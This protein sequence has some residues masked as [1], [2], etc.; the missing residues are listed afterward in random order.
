MK[1]K[2]VGAF[3]CK[4]DAK[5]LTYTLERLSE[6]C[7]LIVA[8]DDG[9]TD[10]S[11]DII[12]SFP[13]V[14]KFLRHPPGKKFDHELNNRKLVNEIRKIDPEW[15]MLIDPDDLVDKRFL[16]KKEELLNAKDVG[17]YTFQEISLWGGKTHYRVDQPEAYAR[18]V[19]YTPLLIRWNPSIKLTIAHHIS[20]R[21]RLV[22]FLSGSLPIRLMKLYLPLRSKNFQS[23]FLRE[24]FFPSDYMSHT[25]FRFTGI[26]GKEVNLDLKK[27][28]YHF[29]DWEYACKKHVNYALQAAIR[30]GRKV[31]EVPDIADWATAR[32]NSEGLILERVSYEWGVL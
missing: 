3:M 32:L 2:L 1:V 20:F 13:K 21:S 7:D 19:S 6:C 25:N 15:V 29:F 30:Q 24:I 31:E 12:K 8:L 16:N 17:R 18:R 9:S 5:V 23:S 14:I 26:R 28:H 11:P 4:N 22:K 10:E 27:I